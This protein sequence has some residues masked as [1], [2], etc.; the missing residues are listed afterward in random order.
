MK[1][2]NTQLSL[3]IILRVLIGWH[4][5]YE[6]LAKLTNPNWSS[7]GY[8]MDSGGFLKGFFES[9]ASNPQVLEVVDFMNTWG[10]IAIGL[11]LVLGLF[12]R[13]A[14]WAGVVLL[15]MYYLSHPPFVGI[16]YSMPSEGNYLV[17]NKILIELSALLVLLV[18]PTSKRIGID[19]LIFRKKEGYHGK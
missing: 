13:V 17:V 3:L 5:L 18:F 6:G 11:G 4:F 9:L 2:T 12:S 16:K 1:Y 7:I 19:R 10:L 15:A 14:V 8:L